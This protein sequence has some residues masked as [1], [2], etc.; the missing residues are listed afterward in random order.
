MEC[1]DSVTDDDATED[2]EEKTAVDVTPDSLVNEGIETKWY[3][4]VIIFYSYNFEQICGKTFCRPKDS[5]YRYR[6][7]INHSV[8]SLPLI[9]I[10]P[11]LKQGLGNCPTLLSLLLVFL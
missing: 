7:L 10:G 8:P 3:G 11:L 4:L 1:D 2:E 6:S 9:S 5:T